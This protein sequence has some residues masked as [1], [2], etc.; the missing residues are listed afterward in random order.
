MILKLTFLNHTNQTYHYK[1]AAAMDVDSL[2][3][4]G[5]SKKRFEVQKACMSNETTAVML[6]YN[7]LTSLNVSTN[8]TSYINSL[9]TA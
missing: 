5:A 8:M 3:N 6:I 2:A 7:K 1:M 9:L 4:N